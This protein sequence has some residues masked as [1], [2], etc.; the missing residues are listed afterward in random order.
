M[1]C[2]TD[3]ELAQVTARRRPSAQARVLTAM[4]IPFRLRPDGT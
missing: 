2:L 1:I 3:D 4:A